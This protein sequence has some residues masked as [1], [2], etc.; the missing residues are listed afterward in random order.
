MD[1]K[2]YSCI[3]QNS[4]HCNC[5]GNEEGLKN[6]SKAR[7][8]TVKA[9]SRKRKDDLHLKL[10]EL[11]PP[12]LKKL[13]TH[14]NCISTY[15]SE[16]HIKRY[17]RKKGKDGIEKQIKLT[18][19]AAP[20]VWKEHCLFCGE[21]CELIKDKKHPDRWRESYACTTSECGPNMLT[22][23]DHLVKVSE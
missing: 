22:Y 15:T 8:E 13:K 23:K 9:K 16:T 5:S 12:A 2:S 14:E 20:F 18:R 1:W 21:K 7:I 17:L 3:F 6:I 4:P 10:L 11:S 19:S